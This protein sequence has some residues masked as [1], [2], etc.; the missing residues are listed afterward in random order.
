MSEASQQ[1]RQRPIT[2]CD[3][4]AAGHSKWAYIA[5]AAIS[6]EDAEATDRWMWAV[7]A[8]G[9]VMLNCACCLLCN[10]G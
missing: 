5:I 6:V 4:E 9:A 10:V 3:G 8:H 1:R 7:S 2:S